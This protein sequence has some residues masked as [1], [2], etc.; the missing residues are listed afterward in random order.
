MR[1]ELDG[2]DLGLTGGRYGRCA[3]D[4]SAAS[5][6]PAGTVPFKGRLARAAAGMAF[7][8]LAA[9]TRKSKVVSAVAG[10]FGLSH[11]VAAAT[12][13]RGCPEM[14]AIPSLVARRHVATDCG[15]WDR[16]DQAI[17]ASAR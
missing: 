2:C 1:L 4:T 15:P 7:L 12:G 6:H 10:W 13:Y 16:I 11:V 14:G 8:G 9:A 3:V 5:N 17:A